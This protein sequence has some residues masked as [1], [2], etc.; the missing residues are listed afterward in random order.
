LLHADHFP[1]PLRIPAQVNGFFFL[2][3]GVCFH[4]CMLYS[5]IDNQYTNIS[6]SR[7]S[8]LYPFV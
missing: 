2:R 3:L 5:E 7:F 8:C 1:D 6:I 4:G